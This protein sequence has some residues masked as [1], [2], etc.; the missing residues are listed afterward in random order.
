MEFW[1]K[2]S[3][4]HWTQVLLLI[5]H[6]YVAFIGVQVKLWFSSALA[7]LQQ[8]KIHKVSCIFNHHLPNFRVTSKLIFFVFFLWIWFVVYACAQWTMV[9]VAMSMVIG[10][11]VAT[12]VVEMLS[13]I[14][15]WWIVF[16][17]ICFM[18]FVFFM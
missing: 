2:L 3:R 12:M 8:T 1:R 18:A 16:F 11:M 14:F 5:V 15:F 9:M 17:S 7:Q 4:S 6:F 10:D 13:V